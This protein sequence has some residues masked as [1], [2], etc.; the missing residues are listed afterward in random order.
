MDDVLV[1]FSRCCSALPGDEIIG[2]ITRG[3]GVS[4]HKKSCTNVPHNIAESSEP[5]RWINAHWA[6]DFKKETFQSTLD[7][8]GVDRTG[9][10]A[11][12]TIQLSLM[13]IAI[14]TLNSRETGDGNAIITAT[15]DVNG[16]EHLKS[17]TQKLKGIKGM[18]SI[19]RK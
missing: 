8:V 2:Y 12:V 5:E 1:R 7:I 4:I 14:H 18:I 6:D 11:D 19:T 3:Y 13:H 17:I 16:L 15:I 10:L 9:F